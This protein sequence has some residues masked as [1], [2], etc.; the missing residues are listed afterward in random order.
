MKK[1]VIAFVALMLLSTIA[2]AQICNNCCKHFGFSNCLKDYFTYYFKQIKGDCYIKNYSVRGVSNISANLSIDVYLV[3][4]GS[5][6]FNFTKNDILGVVSKTN[7]MWNDYGVRFNIRNIKEYKT[8]QKNNVFIDYSE[9]KRLSEKVAGDNIHDNIIDIFFVPEIKKKYLL[10]ADLS[11]TEGFDWRSFGK[12]ENIYLAVI[13]V[14]A[15]NISWVLAHELGHVLGNE[16][17]AYFS[18]QYNF[19][20]HSGCIRNMFYP[21]VFDQ[22]QVDRIE[23]QVEGLLK[24]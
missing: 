13:S 18:G 2:F 6:E 10:I 22:E 9:M 14:K 15:G 5:K 24:N 12:G 11:K 16:D 7:E 19:M 8:L 17:Y 1:Y 21:T 20:T 4:D 3:Y 23:Q